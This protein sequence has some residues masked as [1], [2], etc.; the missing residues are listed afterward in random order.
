MQLG[1]ELFTRYSMLSKG[2]FEEAVRIYDS[3]DGPPCRGE[4]VSIFE[5]FERQAPL[6]FQ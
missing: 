4:D 2:S 1:I 3:M 5:D 6:L